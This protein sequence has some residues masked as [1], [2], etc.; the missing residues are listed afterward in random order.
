VLNLLPRRCRQNSF[1]NDIEYLPFY[2]QSR[3]ISMKVLLVT[4]FLLA[5]FYD[6]EDGSDVFARN[7]VWIQRFYAAL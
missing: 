1:R 6:P 3:L 5:I 7:V 2:K 4:S